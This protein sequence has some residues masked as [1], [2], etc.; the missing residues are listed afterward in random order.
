MSNPKKRQSQCKAHIYHGPGH[1]SS[2][3]CVRKPGNHRFH[4]ADLYGV[5]ASWEGREAFTGY[6]DEVPQ[7]EESR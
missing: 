7:A 5:R 1:Q 3:Q 6:F 2:T 4:S